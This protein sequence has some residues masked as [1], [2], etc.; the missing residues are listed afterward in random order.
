MDINELKEKIRSNIKI[1][2]INILPTGGQSC[3]ILRNKIGL[4]SEELDLHIETSY[5]RSNLKNREFLITIFEHA[6][7]E[8]M[9]RRNCSE[10]I[11]QML[12]KIPVEN[13]G[14]IKDLILDLEDAKY[15][16]PE[17]TLQ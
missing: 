17:E 5:Y 10:V 6:L 9:K 11:E 7:N 12:T 3:G 4:H 15:K 8:I 13:T 16:A 2:T 1:E 14:L